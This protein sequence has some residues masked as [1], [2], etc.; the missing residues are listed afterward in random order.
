MSKTDDRIRLE[1]EI[2]QEGSYGTHPKE[3]C[4]ARIINKYVK[5]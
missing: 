2:L 5:F 3:F 1:F 4:R